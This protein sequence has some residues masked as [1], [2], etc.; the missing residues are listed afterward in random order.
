MWWHWLFFARPDIPERVIT[1]DPDSWYRGDPHLMGRENLDE[2]RAAGVLRRP[3]LSE[4]PLTP[5]PSV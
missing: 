1:A 5:A 2:W 4:R 3:R